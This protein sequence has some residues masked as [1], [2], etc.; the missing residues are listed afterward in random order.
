MALILYQSNT[1][2]LCAVCI[3]LQYVASVALNCCTGI[4][5]RWG[6][7]LHTVKHYQGYY[8][9]L[10]AVYWLVLDI[11]NPA[12]IILIWKINVFCNVRIFCSFKICLLKVLK[13]LLSMVHKS[14][15]AISKK[16]NYLKYLRDLWW[17]NKILIKLFV[18]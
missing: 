15:S 3:L 16:E 4:M 9:V 6:Y 2:I 5:G 1:W 17:I 7:N 18:V 11:V 8:L 12:K 13:L 14:K 10:N